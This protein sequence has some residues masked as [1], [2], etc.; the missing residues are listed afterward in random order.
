MAMERD[1]VATAAALFNG[2][3]EAGKLTS[4]GTESI[5]LAVQVARDHARRERGVD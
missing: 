4:G 5:F 2:V 3:P 1:V